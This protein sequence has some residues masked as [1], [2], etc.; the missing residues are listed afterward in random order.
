M[1]AVSD[2][3]NTAPGIG[4]VL[5]LAVL[6]ESGG[7]DETP[8]VAEA[9][10]SLESTAGEVLTRFGTK[11]ES[12]LEKLSADAARAEQSAK[13]DN[14]HGVSAMANSMKAGG[15]ALRSAV[16][17]SFQVANTGRNPDH[18]TIVLPKPITQQVVDTFNKLF[19]GQ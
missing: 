18:R 5:G 15:T 14:L 4:L 2:F 16:E 1:Q 19:W 8:A 3:L 12:T 17:K 13:V 6:V 7:T 10:Q 9:E 11:A